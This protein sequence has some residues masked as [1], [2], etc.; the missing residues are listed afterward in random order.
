MGNC[1]A[2]WGARS[3]SGTPLPMLR[4]PSP[5]CFRW[6]EE[7]RTQGSKDVRTETLS[8]LLLSILS[9]YHDPGCFFLFAKSAES[10]EKKGVAV[11]I[12]REDCEDGSADLAS[13][14]TSAVHID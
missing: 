3:A 9:L 4:P 2:A 7:V 1:Q 10:H 8:N 5:C 6:E 12:F 14:R 11:S 13:S